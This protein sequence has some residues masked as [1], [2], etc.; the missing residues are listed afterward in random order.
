MWKYLLILDGRGILD[1]ADGAKYIGEWNKGVR[2]GN[3]TIEYTN[4]D[5]LTGIFKDDKV[6][7]ADLVCKSGMT[8]SGNSPIISCKNSFICSVFFFKFIFFR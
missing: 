5:T 3:G 8:Y 7:E 4:G 6:V 2:E 1:F